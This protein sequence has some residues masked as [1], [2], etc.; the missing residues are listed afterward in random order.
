MKMGIFSLV[1][2]LVA[3]PSVTADDLVLR[4]GKRIQ[5][6][7]LEDKGESYEVETDAGRK[8]T[9]KKSDVV[10][11]EKADPKG[12][13]LTGAAFTFDVK[14]DADVSNLL[15]GVDASKPIAG[16]W[17]MEPGPLLIT[18]ATP[19]GRIVIPYDFPAEYDVH[20]TLQK[21]KGDG[22]FYL[23][24]PVGA[25]RMMVG[26]DG[27]GGIEG[28]V[29]S[30]IETSFKEKIF[31]DQ[32]MRSLVFSVRSNR[33]VLTVNGKVMVDWKNADYTKVSLPEKID[34]KDQGLMVGVYDTVYALSGLVVVHPKRQP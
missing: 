31:R 1:A 11:F 7:V 33:F 34:S 20:V 21:R 28:G 16:V 14:K 8:L 9:I 25:R 10:R 24:L 2:V 32:K 19:H 13:P 26:V 18:P 4:D 17:S 23:G 30:V 3:A 5:W 29:D 15:R 27:T 12:M 6:R 22:A